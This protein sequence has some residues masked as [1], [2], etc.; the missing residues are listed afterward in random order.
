M[1]RIINHFAEMKYIEALRE[2]IRSLLE[3]DKDIYLVG[4]DIIDPYGGAFKVTKGLSSIF[5]GRLIPTPMSEQGFTGLAIG[6]AIAGLKPV[7]EIMF[8]D[9]LTLT[10][11]QIVNHATKFYSM[12]AQPLPIVIRTP[13][14]GFR[15]YGAT[16]SQSMESLFFGIPGLHIIAP[17]IFSNPGEDLKYA[18]DL[19]RPV[20]FIENKTDYTQDLILG[21]TIDSFININRENRHTLLSI[22]D[23]D[24]NILLISYG[25]ISKIAAQIQKQL[26]LKEE[27]A[28]DVVLIRD[29]WP[30]D[31]L[32][33]GDL[34]KYRY[35]V[36]LEEGWMDFGWGAGILQKIRDRFVNLK[37][38][39]I[40]ARNCFIPSPRDLEFYVLPGYARV[41]NEI[42]EFLR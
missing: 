20:L 12:Y 17:N 18:L 28:V 31:F 4:E 40:G 36:S 27:I 1:R 16:H 14:G 8:S 23:E 9:F 42:L 3:A 13:S 5:P 41:Y 2:T 24:S 29:L 15:G 11:D 34:D 6:M 30:C 10:V 35:V 37:T 26:Y 33:E 22:A 7:V 32:E 19:N 21:D 38:K 25:G 39:A